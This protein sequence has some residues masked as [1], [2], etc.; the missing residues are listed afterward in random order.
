MCHDR[1]TYMCHYVGTYL[2][3]VVPFLARNLPLHFFG[4]MSSI[5]VNNG[6]DVAKNGKGQEAG[7]C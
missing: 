5:A 4:P 6:S 7:K 1:G 3:G 2:V